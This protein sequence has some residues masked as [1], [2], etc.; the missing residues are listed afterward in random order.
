M[1]SISAIF[2]ITVNSD[3]ALWPFS[4]QNLT[5]ETYKSIFGHLVGLLRQ[6][7]GLAYHKATIYTGHFNA[8]KH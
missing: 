6:D 8:Q 1:D 5:S 7:G 4:I 3:W 2:C